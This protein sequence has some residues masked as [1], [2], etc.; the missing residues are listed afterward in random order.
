MCEFTDK[1]NPELF[2]DSDLNSF[3]LNRKIHNLNNSE[4]NYDLNIIENSG[5]KER[6]LSNLTEGM[7]WHIRLG[8]VSVEYL[9]K[10]KES[11]DSF[12]KIKF[13]DD[14]RDCEA[15]ILAK[16]IKKPF[17]EVRT[18]A[19]KPLYRTHTD[20]LGPVKPLSF[21][22]SNRYIVALIDDYSRYAQTYSIKRKS[23]AGDCLEDYLRKARCMLGENAKASYIRA[24]N[25]KEYLGGKF[26]KV[27]ESEKMESDFSPPHTSQ[28]NGSSERYLRTIECCARALL[29]DSG[30][31][32]TMWNFAIE[33]ATH[34]KNRIPHRS[35]GFKIPLKL[36]APAKKL[37][38][39]KLK[40]FGCIAYVL[41]T[42]PSTKFA[43]RATKTV[44]VGYSNSGYILWHPQT[45]KFINAANVKF[46]E[47]LV[48][49]DDFKQINMNEKT[50]DSELEITTLEP[51]VVF[52]ENTPEELPNTL[53]NT[54]SNGLV[55]EQT[56]EKPK[57]GRKRKSDSSEIKDK[58]AVQIRVQPKRVAKEG[59]NFKIY[60]KQAETETQI[61]DTSFA[62]FTTDNL[63][64][65]KVQF[66]NP[67]VEN[68]REHDDEEDELKYS[69]LATVGKDPSS[70]EEAMASP[71][72]E[73]WVRAVEEELDS[74]SSNEVWKFVDRPTSRKEERKINL[75]DSKW[76]FKKK[77]NAAGTM[78]YKARLV[79]RGFKDKLEYEIRETYAP[80]TRLPLIRSV[81]ALA[82]KYDLELCQMDVKTAFL[83]GELEEE[84]Y[85]K[86]PKGV[87][88]S[89]EVRMNKICKLQK[90]LYGLRI[91]PKKWNKC[92]TREVLKLGLK[93][94][95][96]EP[97]LYTY[98]ENGKM[99]AIALYV[100]DM[101]IASNDVNKL[102]QIKESLSKSFE[103]KDLGEP[104]QFLGMRITRDRRNR[105][106]QIDQKDYSEKI[107]ER[108]QMK[109]CR[110][111]LSPMET[112]Q[113]LTRKLKNDNQIEQPKQKF[114]YREAIG[115]LLYLACGTRPDISF[116][117]NV[118]AR[119]QSAPTVRDWEDVKRLLQYVKGTVDLGLKYQGKSDCMESFSDTSFCDWTDSTSTSGYLILLY[120][121][122]INWRSHKQTSVNKSTCRAE[123][124]AMSEVCS[125][126]VSTDKALREIS[127]V[128]L[129]PV[130]VWCDNETAVKNTQMEGCHKL[131]DFDDD[132]QTIKANLRYRE[133]TGNRVEL[134]E[135]HG[136]FVKELVVKGAV[137]TAWIPTAENPA[138]VFTK[139]L[140]YHKHRKLTMKMLYKI[141]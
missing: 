113:V 116:A 128:T 12:K 81:L 106:I 88:V 43:A 46:I 96:H 40:R 31:P 137:N 93:S 99:A 89:D 95:S 117:V 122:P 3:K 105:I 61:E 130:T 67:E 4:L 15:C 13:E 19:S 124:M 41:E 69:L 141:E 126:I 119:Q 134:S 58:P 17:K 123:Y 78:T 20:I 140:D 125:E 104:K 59:R 110:P 26:N 121:D 139:P 2:G 45:N 32:P 34:I 100:D 55:R 74:M 101:L 79:I 138:D 97:C 64:K 14:I 6:S 98:R 115:S 24:D 25:A 28:H 73:H 68:L 42:K 49:K 35:I 82:N 92:F 50:Q 107:L 127:G 66:R 136:D 48:Y 62:Y 132:I 111:K 133:R 10:L 94:T 39:D 72:R 91:S 38:L 5:H 51:E 18:R 120:G 76:V 63:D 7:K 84:I 87:R 85:M 21:P 1:E 77:V 37:H 80:V 75:I 114:P 23:Q 86:I 108:F 52:S 135:K 112:R 47:K 8:H 11:D 109:D 65:S 53:E 71:E 90:A 44:L 118:L 103:M 57:R 60:A 36:F 70:Y 29:I 33:M 131:N 54:E 9:R 16:M 56:K 129:Y 30:L 83:N 27:M 102:N 22:D